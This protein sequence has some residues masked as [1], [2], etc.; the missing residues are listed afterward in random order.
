MASFKISI[1]SDINQLLEYKS[2]EMSNNKSSEVSD[3]SDSEKNPSTDGYKIDESKRNFNAL[4]MLAC[5]ISNS[6]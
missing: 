5:V 3:I 6:K 2:N 4:D 1:K